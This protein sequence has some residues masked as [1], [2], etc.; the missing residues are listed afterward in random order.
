MDSLRRS[1]LRALLAGGAV[2]L[3][4]CDTVSETPVQRQPS[5]SGGKPSLLILGGTGFVGPPIV[6]RA[7]ESGFE[8]TLFNRGRTNSDLFGDLE[9]LVGDRDGE[10]DSI[11]RE[12][13]AGRTW[14]AVLDLSGYE[15]A[16]VKA[17]ARLL[18]AAASQYVFVSSI[19]A[20]ASFREPN[21]ETSP[22]HSRGGAYGPQKALAER[23]AE[24]ALPGRV[25][26]LRPTYIAGPGDNTDRFTYWPVRVA[27][28]GEVFVPGPEDRPI[29]FVDVRDVA[30][31]AVR[32][33]AERLIGPFN[34][35]IPAGSYTMGQ[36]IAD[37]ETATAA[38][39]SPVWASP[40]FAESVVM[41]DND[42][43][44]WT[45]PLGEQAAFPLV[46]GERAAANGFVTRPPS[47]TIADTLEWWRS[48]PED[49]RILR[50]GL[51]EAREAEVL[52]EWRRRNA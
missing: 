4:G 32:C 40:E 9:L 26:I 46:S 44:I 49:R 10:L 1:V 14:D 25:T 38:G 37:C 20:Y 48:L 11:E 41:R 18:A 47:E 17:A 27:R 29:Q 45:S 13:D 7:I 22:L 15:A 21:E 36:F 30:E 33:V 52:A 42:L 28:G 19:A 31:L 6:R 23:E 39:A 35:V 2:Q 51:S 50:A 34:V 3:S 12:V 16:H 8:V 43:P 5:G 24:A